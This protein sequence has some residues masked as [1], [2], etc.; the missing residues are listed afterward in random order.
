MPADPVAIVKRYDTLKTRRENFIPLWDECA[1]F[2][3]PHRGSILNRQQNA[4]TPG[5]RQTTRLFDATGAESAHNLA[6]NMG[7]SLT[8]QAA[9]WFHLKTRD[10]RVNKIKRVMDWL[11]DTEQRLYLGY[12]QS[13]Y[14]AEVN[15]VYL[16]LAAFGTGCMFVGEKEPDD[17]E[18][19]FGGFLFR[20]H[21]V[22]A[23]VIA[24][25]PDGVV[26][27]IMREEQMTARACA[28]L[29]PGHLGEV[30]Q[31]LAETKPDELVTIL[32]AVYPRT[33][34]DPSKYAATNMAWASCYVDLARKRIIDEGG[35]KD[36]R[37]VV[38]RWE[39][40]SG[41][42]YGRGPGMLAL[43]DI[44]SLNRADEMVLDAGAMAIRP[45]KTILADGVLGEIDETPGGYTVI[46]VPNAI[47]PMNLGAKFDVAQIL[48][49]DRRQRVR[50]IFF[51]EQ[52]QLPTG[53]TMTATE[54][55][56][57]WDTMRRILGPTLGR[58]ES[59]FLNKIIG[60]TFAMMLRRGA[61][62]QPPPE[63]AGQDLD[64]E[65]EGP[66]ARSQK[67]SRLSALEQSIQLLTPLLP[68][69]E[70]M[71][72]TKENLD[73]DAMIRDVFLTSGAPSEWLTDTEQRDQVRAQRMQK[74]A[75][76]QALAAAQQAADA[77]GKAAPMLKTL[78]ESAAQQQPQEAAA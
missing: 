3:V 33:D 21:P 61:F 17:P 52:L 57:R 67:S 66:L 27:T 32:H 47:Q 59:E 75:V 16:D 36:F 23:Y 20:A 56:R 74:E 29:W 78:S 9:P 24:E 69:P 48:N 14:Y 19:P 18:E 12:R 5:Q 62:T 76:M 46:E 73:L 40:T 55:E 43:P 50:R 34:A 63:L 31:G 7:G 25:G 30:L 71:A 10:D 70:V 45:P 26:E 1:E 4:V 41:E 44:R 6:A 38:P 72:K 54:V 37:Y 51:W 13:N 42:V 35:F 65:Y 68:D 58:L 60:L 8:S 2:I 53:K 11:E 22:G 64:I 15:E 28:I 49:E 39:K 77:A